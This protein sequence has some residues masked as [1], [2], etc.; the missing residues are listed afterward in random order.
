MRAAQ[1]GPD[2]TVRETLRSGARKGC[3]TR[4]SEPL[5][6][7][8]STESCA[9]LTPLF[10]TQTHLLNIL[11]GEMDRAFSEPWQRDRVWAGIRR[12]HG[13][14]VRNLGSHIPQGPERQKGE[15]VPVFA[16][17]LTELSI[18]L[19][20]VHGQ[21]M[22]RAGV[23]ASGDSHVLSGGTWVFILVNHSDCPG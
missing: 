11:S 1:R 20:K 8:Y 18:Y 4:R 12:L 10:L 23:L 3:H 19:K 9:T 15:G 2:L 21:V 14:V 7:P 22:D 17:S 13:D 6:S 16:K 5:S